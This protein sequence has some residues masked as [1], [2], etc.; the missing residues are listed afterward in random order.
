MNILKKVVAFAFAVVIYSSS[1]A[2]DEGL[3]ETIPETK[4]EFIESEKKLLATINW[5][6]NTALDQEE[7]KHKKQ[8]A[9]LT[10][11]IINSP[12]VTI[13][14][15][16]RILT[17][18]KK[19]SQLLIFFMAG[20]TKYCLQNNYSADLTKGNVA[21]IRSAIGIYKKGVGLKLD[22]EMQKLIDLDEKGELENWVIERL[23]KS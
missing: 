16:N 21:G 4:Q 7:T 2:Q 5:L 10:A 19:N 3:L 11:W 6:E 20:W 17:F 12:T 1:F 8:Y 13:E 9:L 15:N 22:K 14:V 23:A 18:T